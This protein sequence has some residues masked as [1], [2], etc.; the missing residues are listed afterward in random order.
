MAIYGSSLRYFVYMYTHNHSSSSLPWIIWKFSSPEAEK[1]RGCGMCLFLLDQLVQHAGK[2]RLSAH[3]MNSVKEKKKRP[4]E[5]ICLI[6]W[7]I[8]L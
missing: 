3:L 8:N 1:H 7:Y 6:Y 2:A 5:Q 4:W